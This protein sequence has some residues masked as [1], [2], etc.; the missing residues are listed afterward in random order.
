[1][2]PVLAMSL[3]EASSLDVD[4]YRHLLSRVRITRS[5]QYLTDLPFAY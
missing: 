5:S 4:S 1:M 2:A 3:R